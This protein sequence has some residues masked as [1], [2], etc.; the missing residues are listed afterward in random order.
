MWRD[1]EARAVPSQ[2]LFLVCAMIRRQCMRATCVELCILT[3]ARVSLSIH[4]QIKLKSIPFQ[5]CPEFNVVASASQ[6]L[7]WVGG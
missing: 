4:K 2:C 3:T 7:E 1:K 5:L 6:Y